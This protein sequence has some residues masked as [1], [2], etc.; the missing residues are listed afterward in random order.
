MIT[1]LRDVPETQQM[2]VMINTHLQEV[3]V[4]AHWQESADFVEDNVHKTSIV[5]MSD[6]PATHSVWDTIMD[7]L[8]AMAQGVPDTMIHQ[9]DL[10]SE[11]LVVIEHFDK[12]THATPNE[13]LGQPFKDANSAVMQQQLGF[14]AGDDLLENGEACPSKTRFVH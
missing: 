3:G 11:P 8:K 5:M 9:L 1:I 10:V 7:A 13:F 4:G 6:A 12:I 14:E 2:V